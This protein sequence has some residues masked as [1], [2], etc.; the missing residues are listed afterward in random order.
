MHR[1]ETFACEKFRDLEIR[2][3]GHSRLVAMTPFDRSHMTA[4]T[5]IVILALARTEI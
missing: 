5:Y 4:F 1:F 2:V 3:S